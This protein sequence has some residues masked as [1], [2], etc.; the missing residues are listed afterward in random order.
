MLV[1]CKKCEDVGVTRRMK[2]HGNLFEKIIDIDNIR[3]AHIN[4]SKG[5]KDYDEVM[6]VNL[7]P[8]YYCQEVKRLLESKEY[9]TSKYTVFPKKDKGKDRIMYKLPYFPDRIVQHAIMQVTEQFW[10]GSLIAD[11]Y[12]SIKGRG[13]HKCLPKLKKAVYGST[14]DVYYAQMDV[15][16]F[17]PS[18]SN[19]L[20]K[21][22]IRKKVKCK[23][24]LW[25]LDDIVDSTDGVPIGNYVSQ[26]FGNMYLSAIDHKFKEIYGVKN[27]FRYCDDIVIISNDKQRLHELVAM[28]HTDLGEISLKIKNN[29]KVCKITKRTG[30]DF[31][32]Y[33]LY[34][35]RLLIRKGIKQNAK[36]FLSIAN[37]ASY[38]GWFIHCDGHNLTNKLKQ[39]KLR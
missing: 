1:G 37:K 35:D 14:G 4:A 22:V 30:L 10:K 36:T 25:L 7:D 12:Q 24:T 9:T 21:G 5:K 11:T 6:E 2:R 3:L 16:K 17:Y 8:E 34:S 38:Y 13:I 31:L 19:S 18:I 29:Y 28:M 32:G 39:R 23:D 15:S 20:L 33:V 27:Y 26:Y